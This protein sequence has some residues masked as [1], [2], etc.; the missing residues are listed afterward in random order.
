[1]KQSQFK[2]GV[3]Y[4]CMGSLWWGILG[5][6]FF[7]YISS[8]GAIEV[9]IHRL[10]WTCG[11]LFLSTLFFKKINVL[12][13]IL[14]QKKNLFIL[15]LTSILIFLNWGTWIYAISINKIIDASYGYFIFP[16][17]NVYL[18]YIFLKEKLNKKRI[19]AISAVFLSSIYLLFNLDSLP[20]VGF[21]VAIFWSSYNLLRKKINVDTDVGLF[22]E[23]LFILPIGLVIAYFIYQSGNNDFSFEAPFNIL[24]LFLAGAMTVIPLFL[25]IKGLEKT[26]MATSGLIFFITP[27]SQFLLGFFYYNEPFTGTKLISFIIIWIAVFIYLKDLYEKK[28]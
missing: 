15:F 20:L 7:K 9:T 22:I 19:L 24:M 23:S 18:G 10:I 27:T 28:L 25:F 26:T 16:I 21:L 3:I 4:A 17:L 1:M 14:K 11:I 2:K 5:T 12:K 13:K 8:M 6:I